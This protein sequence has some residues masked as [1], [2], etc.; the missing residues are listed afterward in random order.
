MTVSEFFEAFETAVQD[1]ALPWGIYHEPN[2]NLP[3]IRAYDVKGAEQGYRCFCPVMLVI[4]HRDPESDIVA[5]SGRRDMARKLGMA[6]RDVSDI[7]QAADGDRI[8]DTDGETVN[9]FD[10]N[11]RVKLLRI[12]G[13][14][15]VP[16]A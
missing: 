11:Y 9:L 8:V 10:P 14:E 12:A 16:C 2:E 5:S 6:V 7:M 15:E 4:H 13:A 3:M 1:F